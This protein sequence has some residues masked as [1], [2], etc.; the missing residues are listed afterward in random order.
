[1]STKVALTTQFL[2]G[3][4]NIRGIF[5]SPDVKE[6][7]IAMYER[8]SGQ[9][10]GAMRFEVEKI[11]VM[12]ALQA[13]PKIADCTPMSGYAAVGE[14]FMSG[15]SLRD[16]MSFL[17]PYGKTLQF[18][19][20][21]K[22]R[23]ELINEVPNVVFA[24][25]PC[26]VY[27]CDDFELV[28]GMKPY[29]KKHESPRVRPADAKK[30]LVYMVIDFQ[31]GPQLFYMYAPEVYS[32]RDRFSKP[33]QYYIAAM[34]KHPDGIGPYGPIEAPM[35]VTDEEQAFKK[36]LIN[37]VWNSGGLTK[38]KKHKRLDNYEKEMGGGDGDEMYNFRQ[39]PVEDA[40]AEPVND[41]P[42]ATQQAETLPPTTEEQQGEGY[43][44]M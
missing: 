17:I 19:V 25:E 44:G 8:T 30:E 13:N 3:L 43:D 32:I 33:Y 35:W 2:N 41:T 6:N 29:I 40:E 16:G 7:V 31:T 38:L 15:L 24:H 39:P 27:D 11:L 26:V 9:K 5:D 10:D 4:G 14:L 42:A 12:K 34:K 20:G 28:K 23:I 22:G 37:R 36:T 18:Q 1:M 21:Y